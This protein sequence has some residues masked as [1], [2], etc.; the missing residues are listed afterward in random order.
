MSETFETVTV[1]GENLTV[2]LLL[3]RRFKRPTPGLTERLYAVNPRLASFGPFLPVGTVLRIPVP[4]PVNRGTELA[5]PVR[6][7]G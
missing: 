6:L 3:W 2:S 4:A 1:V 7:W 5:T